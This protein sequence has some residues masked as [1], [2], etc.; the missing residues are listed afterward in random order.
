MRGI[1]HTCVPD[2]HPDHVH[3]KSCSITHCA[4]VMASQSTAARPGIHRRRGWVA[5]TNVACM[6][7][8]EPAGTA[9]QHDLQTSSSAILPRTCDGSKADVGVNVYSC[10]N[11]HAV[12]SNIA[13]YH[14]EDVRRSVST[15]SAVACSTTCY[16]IIR[17]TTWTMMPW[18]SWLLLRFAAATSLHLRWL[19]QLT[20]RH[21]NAMRLF[22]QSDS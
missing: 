16:N 19:W 17:W 6:R 18:P 2:L 14:V 10:L 3:R 22:Q 13:G 12:A 20:T 5:W 11:E 15:A 7:S 21:R 9:A 8:L 4:S 1:V